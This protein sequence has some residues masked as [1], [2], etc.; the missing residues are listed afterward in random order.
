MPCQSSG[1]EQL[2]TWRSHPSWS[3]AARFR[4]QALRSAERGL[5]AEVPMF[6]SA[7]CATFSRLQWAANSA[8][9]SITDL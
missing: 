4:L 3:S 1:D 7:L 6:Q 9:S 5:A 8:N 2:R